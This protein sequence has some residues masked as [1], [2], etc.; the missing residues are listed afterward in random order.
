MLGPEI[1]VLYERVEFGTSA[2]FAFVHAGPTSRNAAVEYFAHSAGGSFD[3][4]GEIPAPATSPT[5][6]RGPLGVIVELSL[7]SVGR[8][9]GSRT[10]ADGFLIVCFLANRN[11]AG[12]PGEEPSRHEPQRS[13]TTGQARSL[14]LA[15]H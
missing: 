13:A 12:R 15:E 8:A 6:I 9:K 4:S 14:G 10:G 11:C 7:P 3:G 2:R 1:P 5:G